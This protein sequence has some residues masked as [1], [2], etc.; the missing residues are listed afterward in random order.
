VF[1]ADP[2]AAARSRTMNQLILAG[3]R[4]GQR[5]GSMARLASAPALDEDRGEKL[6]RLLADRDDAL[7]A[8]DAARRLHRPAHT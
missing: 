4:R 3:A 8:G 1:E 2:E 7:N 5:C 6:Q